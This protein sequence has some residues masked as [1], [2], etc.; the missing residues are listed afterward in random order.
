MS[1]KLTTS[2]F[3]EKAKNVHGEKYDYSKVEYVDA[4][5]KVCI[6]CPEH[7]EFWQTPSGHLSGKGCKIC[8]FEKMKILQR[9]TREEFIEKAK[10]KYGNK[11]DYSKVKYINSQTPVLI[12]CKEHG[13]FLMRPN[14]HLQGQ[15][16]PKCKLHKLRKKFAFTKE[17][18][19]DKARKIHGNRYDYSK[20]EYV[21][22]RTKVC[23]ICP[24]HGEFWQS[25]DKHL[26]GDNCPQCNRSKLE[27]KINN[28]L[29]NNKINFEEQKHF[30]WLGK[31][32]LDFYL[33]EYNVAIECQ[34][35]QHFRPLKRFN[36]I[37]GFTEINNRDKLKYKLCL[38]NKIK[39]IYYTEIK[40]Y[41]TFLNET[42]VKNEKDLMNKIIVNENNK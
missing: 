12:I 32:S 40:E 33:P 13:N 25:P 35:I 9:F 27:E 14:D 20:V 10:K 3:I 6:I 2:E 19:I 4:K 5:T 22:N 37:D 26:M 17:Q 30:K 21:N 7:G 41:Y 11:Y 31:Q 15:E 23:I 38:E 18:F 1:K 34:G 16:C 28:I 24:K 8:G 42:L 29:T 39:L 36:Y